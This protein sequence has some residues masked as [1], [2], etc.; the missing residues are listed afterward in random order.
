MLVGADTGENPVCVQPITV[1]V[2]GG[3]AGGDAGGAPSA[4]PPWTVHAGLQTCLSFVKPIQAPEEMDLTLEE[5][6]ARVGRSERE[7]SEALA[8]YV[9][10]ILA[11]GSIPDAMHLHG[12]IAQDYGLRGATKNLFDYMKADNVSKDL[13]FE[14][15]LQQMTDYKTGTRLF[16]PWSGTQP[17][18]VTVHEAGHQFWYAIVGL[19]LLFGPGGERAN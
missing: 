6:T 11:G 3:G 19:K 15:L 8:S 4:R 1:Y 5:A 14:P 17:E 2:A 12:S 18:S 9:R 16:A 13:F 10:T 7:L